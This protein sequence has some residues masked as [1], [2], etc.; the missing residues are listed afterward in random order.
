MTTFSS[1]PIADVRTLVNRHHCQDLEACLQQAIEGGRN[2]CLPGRL[3]EEAVN[4]LAKA[5]YV[6]N[7][8]ETEQLEAWE[9]IRA[10]GVQMRG[11]RKFPY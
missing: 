8:M 2:D 5:A 1:S 6:R 10:L 3:Q 4:L 9:A 7:R 11:I